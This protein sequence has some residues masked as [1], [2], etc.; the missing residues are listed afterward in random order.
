VSTADSVHLLHGDE[1]FLTRRAFAA[2]RERVLAGAPEDFNL[3]RFDARDRPAVE[4]IVEAARTLPMMAERRLVW[5]QNAELLF[6]KAGDVVEPLVRY[7]SNPDPSTCLVLMAM[8]AVDKRGK[9]YKALQQHGTITESTAP[10]ERDLPAWVAAQAKARGRAL[11]ADAAALLVESVGR[12]LATLDAAVDR[13]TLFVEGNAPIDVGAVEQVVPHSRARTVWELV[14]AV[15]DR[16]AADALARAHELMGQGE[17]ALK[18]LAMLAR[19]FRQLLI[20]RGARANG[21]SPEECAVAAGIPPFRA[22]TFA[23]QLDNYSGRELLAALERL[24]DADRALKSSKLDEALILEGALLD[25]CSRA[26]GVS[27][28]PRAP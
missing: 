13:L 5:V 26:G 27:S 9:L 20:G 6:T 7:V 4:R 2:L 16:K 28:G 17:E 1:A 12:D 18:L 25:L 21:A 10:R 24:A 3:D 19:Q 14:D 8:E 11:T 22:R 15:A 23:R